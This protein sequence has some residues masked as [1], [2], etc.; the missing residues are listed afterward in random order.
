MTPD[1]KAAYVMAQSISALAEIEGMKAE[2]T[3]RQMRGETIAY[4]DEA[5]FSV[6]EKYGIHHNATIGLF[7]E[8]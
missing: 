8:H 5:F 3:Y 4:R 7:N 6:C 2:N 1:Q